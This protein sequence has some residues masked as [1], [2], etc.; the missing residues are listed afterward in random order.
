MLG[1]NVLSAWGTWAAA[2]PRGLGLAVLGWD[3]E[4]WAWHRM[5]EMVLS[6]VCRES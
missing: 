1:Q 3:W 2:E 5:A 4:S 6:A